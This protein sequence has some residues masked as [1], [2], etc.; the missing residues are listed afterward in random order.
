MSRKV[1]PLLP[2]AEASLVFLSLATVAGLWRLF[3]RGSFFPQLAAIVI[4]AHLVSIA[5]RRAGWS[6]PSSLAVSL[7]AMVLTI[8]VVLYGGTTIVGIPTASTFDAARHDL[9]DLGHL[10]EIVQAPTPAIRPF[11]LLAALGLWWA[12]FVADW[13]A[14]RLWVPFEAVVP[15][16][17][18]FIFSS[19]FA[20]QHGQVAASAMYLIG[21]FG[22]L[23]VH[24]VTRQQSSA[25]WVSTD[26][27]RGTNSLLRAG[28]GLAALA[29]I[30][31]VII[32]PNLPQAQSQA[33]VGWR[34]GDGDGPGSRTTVSPFVDIKARLV[35]Q[36]NLELFTVQSDQRSYWRLTALDQFDGNIWSSSGSY[37][38]A[39]GSLPKRVPNDVDTVVAQQTFTITELDTIW[40][41]A[42]FEPRSINA[43]NTS[44]RYEPDSATLIVGSNVPN[45]NGRSYTVQSA[46][47]VFDPNQ[48]AASSAPV[49]GAIEDVD[50]RLPPTVDPRVHEEALRVTAGKTTQYDK[51]LALQNYFRDNF[52]YDLNVPAGQSDDA[53]V[54]FLFHTRRGYCEQFAGTFAVM[55]R[56]IGLPT[57]VAVGFTPGEEDPSKPGTYHV[58]G[59]HAHAWPEVYLAGQGWVLFEPTP[60]RGAPGAQQYTHVAEQQATGGGGATSVPQTSSPATASTVGTTRPR[61]Q[62]A[63][64]AGANEGDLQGGPRPSFW[65]V[66]RFGGRALIGLGVLVV[67]GL[68]YAI[69]V[70]LAYALYRRRR[71]RAAK[72]PGE[73][74][75]LAWQESVEAAQLLGVSPASAETA[76]EFGR[77]ARRTL[78]TEG[79]LP[80]ADLVTAAD[81][82]PEGVDEAEAETALELSDDV[83][84]T[85]RRQSTRQQ[86]MLAALDPRPPDRRTQ[87]SRRHRASAG[88]SE[89]P[90]IEIVRVP[91]ASAATG[92]GSS[93]PG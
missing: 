70:P 88:G 41:P 3:S 55:A 31:A 59:L 29:V 73:Q 1:R 32:G 91:A 47:P 62:D 39:S 58:K 53:I 9:S 12:A 13:A 64:D 76:T 24:R 25:G 80:L 81:Y 84:S 11:L 67:I 7:G 27:Q 68:L 20:S 38:R 37:E 4:V 34:N 10:F 75:R 6:V 49:P 51:A 82:S 77:R 30:A 33:L 89:L 2:F 74:V 8:G 61:E 54:D 78:G 18:V 50:T 23:L 26:V 69:A 65:S 63:N 19:L 14:F 85:V 48:L 57:R 72:Q 92:N 60:S 93:A 22:F 71:R 90:S 43:G 15:T 45:S 40:L 16:G 56:S 46:L 21:A 36:S 44:V 86:R 28:A 17:T 35:S 87:T 79:F 66:D 42:A 5:A 83:T 52:T